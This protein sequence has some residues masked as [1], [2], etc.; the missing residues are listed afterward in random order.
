MDVDDDLGRGQQ[1]QQ[2]EM[3]ALQ[4]PNQ[5][6]SKPNKVSLIMIARINCLPEVFRRSYTPA[7]RLERWGRMWRLQSMMRKDVRRAVR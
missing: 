1:T 5:S 2:Q 4:A 6:K 7:G 3:G